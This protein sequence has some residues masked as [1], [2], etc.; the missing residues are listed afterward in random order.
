MASKVKYIVEPPPPMF[1]PESDGE[2]MADSDAQYEVMTD[3]KFALSSYFRDRADVYVAAN[4]LIYYERMD[5]TKRVAPDVFVV[6][7]THKARRTSYKTFIDGKP[8]SVVFEIASSGTWSKDIL[9]RP[10]YEQLQIPEY[11]MLDPQGDLFGDVLMGFRLVQGL[12]HPIPY[13]PPDYGR[14]VY[15]EQL[16]LELWG[17]RK[18]DD[19]GIYHFRFR[20]PKTGEWLLSQAEAD[21]ER[22]AERK[23]RHEA[24]RRAQA[25]EQ[26]LA[27]LRAELERL[28]S[29]K[30]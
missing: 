24:E 27:K 10:L 11:F 21:L 28:R 3:T 26:E 6:K 13:L 20:N 16:E 1:Y 12:Y 19:P 9:K 2:P 8:P 18:P 14:G 7:G 4:L 5:P 30:P 29:G 23:A 15:S 17:R 22:Q 25:A